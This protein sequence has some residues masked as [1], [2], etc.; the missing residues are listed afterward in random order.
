MTAR[1]TGQQAPPDLWLAQT[2]VDS[3]VLKGAQ[4]EELRQVERPNEEAGSVWERAVRRGYTDDQ[5]IVQALAARFKVQPADLG[6]ADLR[7]SALLPESVARK[8]RVVPVAADDRTIT[9]A[10]SDPRNLDLE[11]TIRF[12]TGRRVT[13]Q[14]AAPAAIEKKLD[15]AYRPDKA[16]NLIIDGLKP[17]SLES[18]DE[19]DFNGVERDP[20]LD[21][22]MT[23]L[24][25]A[26]IADGVREG[27]SDIHAEPLSDGMSV[28][29]RI[30]GVL[31]EVMRL[32]PNAGPALVRRVK[33]LAK[34]D[35]TD[36]LR[37]H[38]GR[39][40]VRID[41]KVID[42]R[43]A[44]VPVARRG[45]KVVIRILDRMNLRANIED[46][47][48]PAGEEE[49][50][51]KLL[52][53]REGMVL[54]T[55]P[56]GSG[57][58]TT[59][60]AVINELRTGKVNIITVEDPVEYDI[61]GI[62]QLQ[63]TEA[64]NFTFA[65]ALRS[66][67][68][69]DP[70]ILLVGEIRDAETATIA[71]QAGLSG[72]MVLSTLHTN[73]APSAVV[74]LR[75]LGADSFKLAAVLKGVVAQR[76]V[77]RL[78][79]ACSVPIAVE[80]LPADAR[81]PAGQDAQPRKAVGCKACGGSGYKGRL[82]VLEIMPINEA[83]AHK[84]E[85]GALPDELLAAARPLGMRTL[86]ESALE[87]VW[88]GL[89]AL[90]EAVRVLGEKSQD[91]ADAE[92]AESA[93]EAVPAAVRAAVKPAGDGKTRILVA[94]DD[95][96][97]RRLVR[98][99]LE[100]DGYEVTEAADGLDAL[101]Q[102]E[103]RPFDLMMLDVDMPR[104]DGLGVLEELRARIRTSGVPVIVLTARTVDTE[105]RVLDLGAQDFLSKPVQPNSLQA[106]V[107]AVLRRAK[108]S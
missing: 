84:V 24:V 56:T 79:T 57:K 3:G 14:V 102:V 91:D 62:S 80:E 63:V 90:E 59:L 73:D 82:A 25:D 34:L 51:R 106:R 97:M 35:V 74:R 39:A 61:P 66:V 108:L 54:V 38:D 45:E 21:A 92:S 88:Q 33:I 16:I 103:S 5:A 93:A 11:E 100:R 53:H 52:G 10:T 67:L 2:L 50:L 70:D 12:V 72:H 46:L 23:R 17:S 75:D 98:S 19:I 81:P 71:I 104:L 31:N 101:E 95:P 1:A 4:A 9:L 65:T 43:V 20:A 15:E 87:R 99:I 44:T 36:P 48:L 107:K 69:Q 86:W 41:G 22:P 58:T 83:I 105:T 28:R 60:Y 18:I 55:G 89:T 37:P 76:L 49:L 30:D 7:T 42:L 68:R 78:C 96:Q 64:Q 6:S 29:Y 47:K 27:A 26:M 13:I 8:H 94:D 85:A 77:R 40:G 32:P